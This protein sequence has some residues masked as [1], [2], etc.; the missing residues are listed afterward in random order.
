MLQP[1]ELRFH[2]PLRQPGLPVRP[3]CRHRVPLNVIHQPLDLGRL[4]L[5]LLRRFRR[6][7]PLNRDRLDNLLG[8]IRVEIQVLNCRAHR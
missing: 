1:P 3:Q 6:R 5:E 4:E 2:R 7:Q 8:D